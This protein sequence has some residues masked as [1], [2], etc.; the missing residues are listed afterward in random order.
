MMTAK[1]VRDSLCT[2]GFGLMLYQGVWTAYKF[3][4]ESVSTSS[5]DLESVYFAALKLEARV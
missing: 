3:D 4:D 1:N 2:L 5:D